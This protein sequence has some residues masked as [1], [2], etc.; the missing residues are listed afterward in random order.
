MWAGCSSPDNCVN[1]DFHVDQTLANYGLWVKSNRW[2]GFVNKVLLGHSHA[3][4]PVYYL[5]L[6]SCYNPAV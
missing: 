3:H 1:E 4:S 2:P 6:S 5:W